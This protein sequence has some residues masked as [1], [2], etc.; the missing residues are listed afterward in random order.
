[1]AHAISLRG[2]GSIARATQRPGVPAGAGLSVTRCAICSGV[3]APINLPSRR[4]AKG[5]VEDGASGRRAG[6]GPGSCAAAGPMPT[7]TAAPA[8]A[9]TNR[10]VLRF[11]V[12]LPLRGPDAMAIIPLGQPM[13]E[14]ST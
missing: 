4:L 13:V 11:I 5:S 6:P 9:P 10:K 2:T 3:S 7:A 14:E 8:A 12:S 1:M